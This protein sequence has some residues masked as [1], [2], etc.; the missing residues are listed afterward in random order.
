MR[1]LI[2]ITLLMIGCQSPQDKVKPES[3]PFDGFVKVDE[4]NPILLPSQEQVMTCPITGEQVK[5]E[6]RNVLNP[7]AIVRDGKVYLFYRAQDATG[8]SRIGMAISEDGLNFEKRPE[9]VFY[10]DNDEMKIYEWHYGKEQGMEENKDYFDGVEDPRIVESPDG[11]F[12]MTYT[13]YDGKTARLC[14]AYSEDLISWEKRGLVLGG[15]KYKHTWSKAGAIVSELI[16]DRVVARKVGDKYWMYYGDTDLFMA[17]SDDLITWESAENEENGD[18]ISVLHPR[19]GYFDSRLVEPGPY[20]L[21]LPEGIHMIYN[22]SNA[23]NFNDPSMPKFTYAPG[24]VMFDPEQPYK[25][26]D[27]SDT[28]LFKPDK[29]YE[30]E[31]EVNEVCFV[32]G[33]VFFNQKWYLYYG[34]ADSKIAVAIKNG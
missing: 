32:E 30:R 2:Y 19:K 34:T 10:P 14:H 20:A 22:A 33:L 4:L 3:W 12:I 13:S 7:S 25:L 17:T 18:R 11:S 21:Y 9:P 8:T 1:N 27:R 6:S 26:I 15:E 24:Q 31:G 23:A 5:W 16:G 29:P 28:Y